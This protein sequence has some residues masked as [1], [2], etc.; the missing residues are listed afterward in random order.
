M[1]GGGGGVGGGGGEH[2]TTTTTS[3]CLTYSLQIQYG[4][5]L[6]YTADT[7]YTAPS[8]INNEH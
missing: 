5:V 1:G 7:S 2:T 8:K 3:E 4:N 6:P